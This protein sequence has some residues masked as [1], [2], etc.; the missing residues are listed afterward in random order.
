MPSPGPSTVAP[1]IA[2][3]IVDGRASLAVAPCAL[4]EI[5]TLAKLEISMPGAAPAPERARFRR[6]RLREAVITVDEARLH[7][8]VAPEALADGGISDLRVS[9]ADGVIRVRGHARAGGREADFTACARVTPASRRRVRVTIDDVRIYGFLPLAAPLLGGAVLAA[10]A[11]VVTTNG[12]ATPHW[13]VEVDVLDLAVYET[14][15]AWG[16]RLPDI[17]DARLGAVTVS[18]A[19]VTLAW[20]ADA[21]GADAAEVTGV[22]VARPVAEADDLLARGDAGGALAIYRAAAGDGVDAEAARRVLELLLA[23]EATLGEAAAELGALGEIMPAGAPAL[24]LAAAVL[25]AER[26]DAAEAARAYTDVA[27]TAATRGEAD[28][29]VVARLAAAREW[30][31]AGSSAEARP[32]LEAVLSAHPDDARAAELFE[33]CKTDLTT[34]PAERSPEAAQP[35]VAPPP[36]DAAPPPQT[37]Q[38]ATVLAVALA[39]AELAETANRPDAA[40]AA[41][42]RALDYS[43]PRDP[44]RA[45]L[46]RRLA[47]LCERL[48]D[49]EGAIAAL[50]QFLDTAA[51]GP[52]VAPAWRRVVELHARRGDPQ[53]AARALIA[54][55]DDARTG[56]TDEERGAALTAAAGILRK[57]LGLAGDAVMVL[58]RAIALDP[59]SV[60]TLDALQATA[61]ESSNW[62]RLADVLERKIDVVARGPVEQ[63]DLLVQLADVY[64][65]HLQRGARARDTH[66]RALQLDACFQPSLVWLARDAWVRGDTAAA[67]AL[68][69][70]LAAT[71]DDEPR[72]SAEQRAETHVRLGTL[73]RRAGD[74]GTAEREAERALVALPT[75]PA[76]LD[77]LIDLLEAHARHG[78][79]ADA[80]ARRIATDLGPAARADLARRRAHALERAGRTVEA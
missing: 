56:S 57:R 48:G 17:S 65:H 54:S 51:P 33:A 75:H 30:L 39:E 49:E 46:A 31:R 1:D 27:T 28:D 15:A 25:A 37:T 45:E 38:P 8:A 26:G 35:D 10:T 18:P 74:D 44:A 34:L 62:E 42:R 3:S 9:L 29:A 69:G 43:S 20:D 55:A 63:K 6:G 67:V 71:E 32:L 41:L 52:A 79:L 4:A 60:E 23:R 72:L 7:A 77:L 21:H 50:Q 11:A 73:A 68:Y 14:F 40:A 16:W 59:R 58:E 76:A 5:A 36:P 13:S 61:V 2:L 80:L 53:A 78:E 70:R 12:R 64:D 24:S 66:E 22:G 47:A 19:G